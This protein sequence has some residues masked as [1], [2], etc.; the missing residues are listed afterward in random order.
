MGI[1]VPTPIKWTGSVY[2][3][4]KTTIEAEVEFTGRSDCRESAQSGGLVVHGSTVKEKI[5]QTKGSHVLED[6]EITSFKMKNGSS[7]FI[8]SSTITSLSVEENC[9]SSVCKLTSDD[10]L[11]SQSIFDFKYSTL[12]NL[13]AHSSQTSFRSCN[14]KENAGFSSTDVTMSSVNAKKIG[15]ND[16]FLRIYKGRVSALSGNNSHLFATASALAS[17]GMT[18]NSTSD[19][20]GCSMTSC[21]NGSSSSMY[22]S[23]CSPINIGNSGD[24]LEMNARARMIA[25]DCMT[26]IHQAPQ[27]SLA[28]NLYIDGNILVEGRSVVL[29]CCWCAC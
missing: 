15:L 10:I 6:S 18:D 2:L 14:L 12:K 9:L 25:L 23:S 17:V 21:S 19:L 13:L 26:V 3:G 7:G 29:G 4:R 28:G 20:R 16:S 8:R 1:T 27:T 11:V 24:L 5:T 22:V